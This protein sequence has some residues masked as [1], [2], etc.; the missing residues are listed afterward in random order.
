[1]GLRTLLLPDGYLFSDK[2]DLAFSLVSLLKPRHLFSE[3]SI[4]VQRGEL[5]M[6]ATRGTD[7]DYRYADGPEKGR[8]VRLLHLDRVGTG[9]EVPRP[10]HRDFRSLRYRLYFE[11][12]RVKHIT[13]EHLV[14]ELKYGEDWVTTLL[15]ADGARLQAVAEVIPPERFEALQSARARLR[16]RAHLIARL[17]DAM[18]SQIE[19][20][21]PFD[22]P[23]TEEGQQDGSLR[24]EWLR[25]YARG[26]TTFEFNEDR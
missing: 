9:T 5:L 18:R 8:V 26:D 23:K 16:L 6:R 15:K 20:A 21:L 24:P 22:E 25:A 2:P 14:A 12:A 17:R 1:D 10:L 3:S 7:G 4:W 13:E 19:E 11:R